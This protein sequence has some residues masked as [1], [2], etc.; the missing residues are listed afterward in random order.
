MRLSY[1]LR[2]R[3][4]VSTVYLRWSGGHGSGESLQMATPFRVKGDLFSSGEFG[5]WVSNRHPD[6]RTINKNMQD[7]LSK[8]REMLASATTRSEA[9]GLLARSS[10][11]KVRDVVS[12]FLRRKDAKSGTIKNYQSLFDHIMDYTPDIDIGAIDIR[13]FDGFREHMVGY[14]ASTFDKHIRNLKAFLRWASKRYEVNPIFHEFRV[15]YVS[16]DHIALNPDEIVAIRVSARNREEVFVMAMFMVMVDT[17]QAFSDVM[18]MRWRDLEP[19]NVD[20][21]SILVWRCK[22]KKTGVPYMAPLIDSLPYVETYGDKTNDYVWGDMRMGNGRFNKKLQS[23][24]YNAGITAT[25]DS[26]K[27]I[28]GKGTV[29]ESRPKYQLIT[30]H[31][32]RRTFATTML[33]KGVHNEIVRCAVGISGDDTLRIYQKHDTD[34]I[35][36]SIFKAKTA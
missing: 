30:S 10:P 12:D 21:H 25:I 3:R 26:T 6:H 17:G 7:H 31:T 36:Q 16:S 5:P 29:V 15:S 13:W 34:K 14:N 18:D 1:M 11:T 27:E 9:E 24:G 2:N 22:R 33:H 4:T 19:R 28:V 35:I 23:L 20:G 8:V 32:G